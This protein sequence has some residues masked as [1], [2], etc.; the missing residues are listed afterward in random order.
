MAARLPIIATAKRL[1]YAKGFITLGLWEEALGE[2]RRIRK[3]DIS[4]VDVRATRVDAYMA[5]KQWDQVITA[6]KALTQLHPEE[7]SAWIAWA[8]A[9]RERQE[10]EKAQRVLLDGE[11]LHG[12]TSGVLH[13]NLACYA[14]LLGNTV[15]AKKRL[16]RAVSMDKQWLEAALEDKDLEALWPELR[17]KIER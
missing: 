13:Y 6:A 7:E 14:S 3:M 16:K 10:V 4:R 1:E 17:R 11:L 15:E 8:Y 12:K 9:L 5:G 2:L